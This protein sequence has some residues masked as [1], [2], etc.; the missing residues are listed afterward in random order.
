MQTYETRE[1][2]SSLMNKLNKIIALLEEIVERERAV[3]AQAWADKQDRCTC[4]EN[5]P[6]TTAVPPACPVHGPP[7]FSW[8]S[9]S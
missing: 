7:G 3:S 2:L 6:I 8:I 5:Y 1:N 9:S 4:H